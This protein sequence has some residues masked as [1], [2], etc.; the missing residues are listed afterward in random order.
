MPHPRREEPAGRPAPSNRRSLITRLAALGL[1]AVLGAQPTIAMAAQL[2]S[3]LIGGAALSSGSV[4]ASAAP[5]IEA[6]AGIL[7][8]SDGRTLWARQA[9]ASRAMASTTKLMTA[10]V[11]LETADLDDTVTISQAAAKA[12]WALGLRAGEKVKVGTLLEYLLVVSSNDAAIALA[13]HTAGSVSAFASRMN[14]RALELGLDETRFVNPHGLDV[15]GHYSSPSDLAV[16]A[17]TAMRFPEFQRIVLMRSVSLPRFETRPAKTV[18]ATNE[19]LGRYEGLL[20]GKTGFTNNAKYSFVACAERDGVKLTAVVLGTRSNSV[21]FD[22]TKRLLDWG[23]S[24]VI[25]HELGSEDGTI[26]ELPLAENPALTV[27]LRVKDTTAVPVFDLEGEVTQQLEATERVKLPVFEGQELGTVE[28]LQAGRRLLSAPVVAARSVASAEETVG[29]VPVSDYLDRTV[30]VRAGETSETVRA[31]DTNQ[32]V[33]RRVDIDEQ[34][35]APVEPGQIVGHISYVQ[36]GEL[37]V[38]V[39]VVAAEKIE[40]PGFF[41]SVGITLTR[42]W[43]GIVG[44]QRMAVLTLAG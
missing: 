43:R 8:L 17:D 33:Y 12:P 14:E 44:G 18:K 42:G 13:E 28:V 41:E 38:R 30:L 21:R 2:P 19:L 24:H 6:A 4:P 31:F 1:V 35:A 40:A 23:F 27:P 39:P 9:D 11:V 37:V 3:D 16:L 20:G 32:P 7:Q 15:A 22:Q 10:I 26:D 36:G 5:D 29:M 34:I 25:L